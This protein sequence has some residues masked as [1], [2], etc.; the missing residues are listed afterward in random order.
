MSDT[1]GIGNRAG[2]S[3]PYQ[4]TTD[5]PSKGT[6]TPQVPLIQDIYVDSSGAFYKK[7]LDPKTGEVLYYP[8]V[9]TDEEMS[10]LVSEVA[11]D[12]VPTVDDREIIRSFDSRANAIF[13]QG[14]LSLLGLSPPLDPAQVSMLIADAAKKMKEIQNKM[15]KEDISMNNERSKA[16]SEKMRENIEKANEQME[17]AAKERE[18]M[19]IWDK[20]KMAFM[21]IAGAIATVIGAA[22][23]ATG[24]GAA[25][26]AALLTGGILMIMGAINSTVQKE[27]GQGI[28]SHFILAC[29][30]DF[31]KDELWKAELGMSVAITVVALAGSIGAASGLAKGAELATQAG[32]FATRAANGLVSRLGMSGDLASMQLGLTKINTAV[33]LVVGGTTASGDIASAAVNYEASMAESEAKQATAE[34]TRTEALKELI[35]GFIDLAIARITQS[36]ETFTAVLDAVMDSLQDTAETLKRAFKG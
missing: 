9:P 22:L 32:N 24:A 36:G 33:Q 31:P 3:T 27:T 12:R 14:F 7:T 28:F 10:T 15:D 35:E 2:T 1:S 8:H 5:L 6:D 20:I 11:A 25:L 30:P 21:Y 16:L 23:L 29:N 19:S 4:T 13:A 18:N 26:G 17:K 34:K